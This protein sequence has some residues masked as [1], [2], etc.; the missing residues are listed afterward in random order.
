MREFDTSPHALLAYSRHLFSLL[1][2]TH[3]DPSFL[4][5]S[6][7][8]FKSVKVVERNHSSGQ[9]TLQGHLYIPLSVVVAI[10][11]IHPTVSLKERIE[12]GVDLFHP[13]AGGLNPFSPSVCALSPSC[14]MSHALTI[15]IPNPLCFN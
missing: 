15:M 7:I 11:S 1:L 13:Q 2:H 5:G 10:R 3:S 14:A 9:A 4:E 6:N 8:T 12:G